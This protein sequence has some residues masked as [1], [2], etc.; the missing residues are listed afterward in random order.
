MSFSNARPHEY[1]KHSSRS[2]IISAL[3]FI[4]FGLCELNASNAYFSRKSLSGTFLFLSI[5]NT[6]STVTLGSNPNRSLSK[7]IRSVSRNWTAEDT[8]SHPL[9]RNL[10]LC[11]CSLLCGTHG[12]RRVTDALELHPL[13]PSPSSVSVLAPNIRAM[14][15]LHLGVPLAGILF[16][17]LNIR[18]DSALVTVLLR[19]SGTKVLFADHMFLQIAQG[20]CEILSKN[21]EKAWVHMAADA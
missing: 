19:H 5:I 20:V 11:R 6:F 18:H 7:M 15:E 8:Q 13:S 14:V 2:I 3:S 21:S 16:C 12:G 1:A 9:A 4:I 17:T 10:G